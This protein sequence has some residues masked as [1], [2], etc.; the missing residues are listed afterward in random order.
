MK[1]SCDCASLNVFCTRLLF[2]SFKVQINLT[3]KSYVIFYATSQNTCSAYKSALNV[4]FSDGHI[5]NKHIHFLHQNTFSTY[6]LFCDL[7][8]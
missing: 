4:I 8:P 6:R 3:L 5:A 1:I 7:R 2:E